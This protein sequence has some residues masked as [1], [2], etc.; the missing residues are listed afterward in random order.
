MM[1]FFWAVVLVLMW[2]TPGGAQT[3]PV[4]SGEHADFTRIVV[5]LGRDATW[6]WTV[7]DQGTSVAVRF[8]QPGL[9]FDLS[10]VFD[11]IPRDRLADVT[12]REPSVLQLQLACACRVTEYPFG[13][14]YLV[15]DIFDPAP[16]AQAASSQ[17]SLAA[18][19]DDPPP[20]F[21]PVW[22]DPQTAGQAS[23]RPVSPRIAAGLPLIPP[24]TNAPETTPFAQVLDQALQATVA[25]GLLSASNQMRMSQANQVAPGPAGA[26]MNL[27]FA[28]LIELT[29]EMQQGQS[30][31][32]FYCPLGASELMAS[33]VPDASF[34][35]ALTDLRAGTV[36]ATGRLLAEGQVRLA[37]FQA[38]HG[39]G[40]EALS[41]LRAQSGPQI[42]FLRA[43]ANLMEL[44][45]NIPP[46]V[47]QECP[48]FAVW[49]ALR[50]AQVGGTATGI[51]Q[52]AVVTSFRGLPEVTRGIIHA[53][54]L[55]FLST[56][57]YTTAYGQLQEFL[58]RTVDRPAAVPTDDAS[59]PLSAVETPSHNVATALLAR[60]DTLDL[61]AQTQDSDRALLDSFRT[62]YR[63]TQHEPAFWAAA[64]RSRLVSDDLP[65]AQTILDEGRFAY[66][67]VYPQVYTEFLAY[68]TDQ[69]D[70]IAFLRV[71]M[72]LDQ[73]DGLP[74]PPDSLVPRVSARL[75]ELGF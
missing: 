75:A 54:L 73:P 32:A 56:Q 12:S 17:F 19:E 45:G 20:A 69:M 51:D 27:G 14:R 34:M 46:Q 30:R 68:V 62:E 59:Q 22:Q 72:A 44:R 49:E 48:G 63:G 42:T 24:E 52:N 38:A 66:D 7:G 9:R 3:V 6:D 37:R 50:Q 1:R 16:D 31:A 40:V 29:Q 55:E 67:D 70:D 35:Q 28:D 18:S 13:A 43:V 60:F 41:N 4:R 2:V 47:F 61:A 5:D 58:D 15:L 11:L 74:P 65:S 36:D 8:G 53:R 57:G 10:G 39:L 21:L 23:T 64:V 25:E 26:D 71:A 33:W